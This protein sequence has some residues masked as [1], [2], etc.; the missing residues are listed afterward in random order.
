VLRALPRTTHAELSAADVVI[1]RTLAVRL[2]RLALLAPLVETNG[3]YGGGPRE[4]LR[5]RRHRIRRS[6]TRIAL[7]QLVEMH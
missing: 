3:C 2:N 4:K 7:V 6:G 1:F 5:G